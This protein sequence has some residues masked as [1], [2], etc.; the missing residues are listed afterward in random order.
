LSNSSWI[1]TECQINRSIEEIIDSRSFQSPM[2]QEGL[3]CLTG[4]EKKIRLLLEK[5]W[6]FQL[7]LDIR[8][9]VRRY[10]I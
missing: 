1:L 4:S 8:D 3:T 6:Q 2:N 7:S 9:I 5:V 10:T